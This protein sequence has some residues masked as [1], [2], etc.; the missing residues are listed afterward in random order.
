VSA[1]P[2]LKREAAEAL[3]AAPAPTGEAGWAAQVRAAAAARLTAMG[4]PAKRDEY[5]RYTDPA[6][7]MTPA[8]GGGDAGAFVGVAA[9][10]FAVGEA[11]PRVAGVEATTL[12]AALKA[13]LGFARELFGRLEAAG[14]EKVARP[15]AAANTA[16]AT[17]GFAIRATGDVA[18]P[19]LLR[20]GP[21]MARTVVR[22]EAG[23]MATL[24]ET[25]AVGNGCLEIDVCPGGSLHHVRLQDGAA[26]SATHL[27]ARIGAGA[28]LRSFTLTMDGAVTRNEVVAELAGDHASLHVG[29]AVL[30][31][32]ESHVD[33]TVFVTHGALHGQS[34]QVF[35][36]V[37]DGRARAVFQGKIFVRPGAQKTD[38]YQIS[39]A[40]LLAEGATFSAKP[41]LEIYADDVAC[42]HGSTT[43]AIDEQALFY[44]RARGAPRRAAEALLVAAFVDEAVAEVADEALADIL[45]AQVAGWMARR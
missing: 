4:G 40:I 8:A 43:G 35:K 7:L 2:A 15:L 29:G 26:P 27:F 10:L 45:R 14:Q 11:P 6:P 31:T 22:V 17:E 41:E 9:A 42:S 34:R 20:N 38:G 39:Q 23:A 18:M 3:L 32:G 1:L 24:I 36:N 16:R 12:S 21:A 28:A 5:W 19:I 13:D 44:L 25:G 30:A 37:V 33:N